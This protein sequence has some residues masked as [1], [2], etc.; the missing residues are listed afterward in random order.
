MYPSGR[1]RTAAALDP[2]P[3]HGRGVRGTYRQ[4][5]QRHAGGGDLRRGPAPRLVVSTDDE[6]ERAAELVERAHPTAEAVEPGV[7]GPLPGLR[8]VR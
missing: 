2:E 5:V 8:G 3:L 6:G 1:T 7:R 4:P